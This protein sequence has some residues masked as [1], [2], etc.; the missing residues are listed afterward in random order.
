MYPTKDEIYRR[1]DEL[2]PVSQ[3]C[4]WDNDGL[5]IR[6]EGECRRALLA[7]DVTAE[8]VKYASENG[9][10]AIISHHPMIFRPLKSV[11][12]SRVIECVR[13]GIAVMSFHT[14]LDAN[15]PGVNDAL[16]EALGLRDVEVH[17]M[18]RAGA[19]DISGLAAFA[20]HV[21]RSLSAPDVRYSGSSE[22]RRVAV[23]GGSGKDFIQDVISLGCDTYVTGEMSYNSVCDAADAGLN[24]IEAG[25]YYTE[26]PVLGLLGKMISDGWPDVFIGYYDSDPQK[27][28]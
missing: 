25:H 10:D 24:V 27:T 7:L 15:F 16:A 14:R 20:R 18:I 21:G 9:Y 1:L 23:L 4:E 13:R 11:T 19:A 28:V 17:D 22:V 8:T 5:M 3:R 26:A 12:D 2:I 6:G